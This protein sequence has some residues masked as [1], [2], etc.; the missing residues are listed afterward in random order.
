[1]PIEGLKDI[2]K[3]EEAAKKMVEDAELSAEDR[4]KKALID[5]EKRLKELMEEQQKYNK[6]QLED[7]RREEDIKAKEKLDR[8]KLLADE[9][10]IQA[11]LKL[12][13]AVQ[14]VVERIVT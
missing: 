7:V 4:I 3:A 2:I 1:M 14:L 5:S 9:I 11:D 10:K 6:M 12:S 8:V 13:A